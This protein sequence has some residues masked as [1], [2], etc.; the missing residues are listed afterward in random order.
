MNAMRGISRLGLFTLLV[1]VGGAAHGQA[2][3]F[4]FTIGYGPGMV[5]GLSNSR[6]LASG[7][8]LAYQQ[9]FEPRFGMALDLN[10]R[11]DNVDVHAVDGIISAKYFTSDNDATAFYIGSFFGIQSLKATSREYASP[12]IGSAVMK[13]HTKLQFPI[14][15]RAGVRGGLDGY[16]AELFA[17]AGYM[18]GNGQL[19]TSEGEQVSTSPVFLSIG[20]SFLGFGWDHRSR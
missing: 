11:M 17:Q 8:G 13:D 7:L 18:I 15:L 6:Q 4:N 2:S 5:K 10:Y 20:F 12:G 9:D 19:Y 1:I 14:G 16:F 3:G